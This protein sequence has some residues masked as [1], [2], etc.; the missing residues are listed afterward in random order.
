MDIWE[1]DIADTVVCDYCN[2]DYTESD[3]QCGLIIDGY[4]VCPACEKPELIKEATLVCRTGESFKQFVLRN[5]VNNKIGV[6][7]W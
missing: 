4:A 2:D 7:S 1:I 5:R 3:M 6:Y